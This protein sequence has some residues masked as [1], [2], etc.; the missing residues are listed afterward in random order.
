MS[1]NQSIVYWWL[2]FRIRLFTILEALQTVIKLTF[3][4]NFGFI[5]YTADGFD[6]FLSCFNVFFVWSGQWDIQF[7]QGGWEKQNKQQQPYASL[8]HNDTF[9][10]RM[11]VEWG[12]IVQHIC[13]IQ[14]EKKWS[15]KHSYFGTCPFEVGRSES[16]RF[17]HVKHTYSN[18]GDTE[19]CFA[20]WSTP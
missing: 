20:C 5:H 12:K 17:Y 19:H 3:V 8:H 6:G 7:G 2:T 18:W 13:F 16:F 9:Q 1:A 10:S 11:K 4:A 15:G 14:T